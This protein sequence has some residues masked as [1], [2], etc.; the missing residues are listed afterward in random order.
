MMVKVIESFKITPVTK[1]ED[2]RFVGDLV[3]RSRDPIQ[4][5]FDFRE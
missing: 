1:R 3:L 2:V 4:M 5:K